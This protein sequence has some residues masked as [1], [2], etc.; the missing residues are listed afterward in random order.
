VAVAAVL[1]ESAF[2]SAYF[3]VEINLKAMGDKKL[4]HSIRKELSRKYNLIK[5]IGVK[6][7]VK[8]GKIIRG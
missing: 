3:N 6:T 1:L 2:S 7:E 4:T 5:K 8:V